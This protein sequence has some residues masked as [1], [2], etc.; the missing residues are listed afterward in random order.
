MLSRE[1]KEVL[2]NINRCRNS[3]QIDEM[4]TYRMIIYNKNSGLRVECALLDG[5]PLEEVWGVYFGLAL[6]L[7]LVLEQRLFGSRKFRSFI[8]CCFWVLW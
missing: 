7:F 4:S 1:K 2:E 3:M 6:P 5:M 8:G